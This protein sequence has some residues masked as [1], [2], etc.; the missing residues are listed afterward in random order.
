MYWRRQEGRRFSH[1]CLRCNGRSRAS[2]TGSSPWSALG[3]KKWQYQNRLIC[4][5]ICAVHTLCRQARNRMK[6]A[7]ICR[8]N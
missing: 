7:A 3:A 1:R 6:E 4:V 5:I 2:A 8:L